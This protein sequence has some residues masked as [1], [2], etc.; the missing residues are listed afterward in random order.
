MLRE[1]HFLGKESHLIRES[2]VGHPCCEG[3]TKI[4]NQIDI[5]FGK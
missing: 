2:Q 4:L 1:S 5:L 3:S